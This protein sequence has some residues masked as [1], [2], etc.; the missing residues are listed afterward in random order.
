MSEDRRQK[1]EDRRQK[2]ED[3]NPVLERQQRLEGA[4]RDDTMLVNETG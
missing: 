4:G 1:S 3:R 2:A